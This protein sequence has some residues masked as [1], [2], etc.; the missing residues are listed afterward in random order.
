V[1]L[2]TGSTA[3][4]DRLISLPTIVGPP[5]GGVTADAGGFVEVDEALK[6]CGSQRVWAAG[7]C[8]AAGLEHSALAAQLADAA[9]AAI[10]LAKGVGPTRPSGAPEL[11]GILL[12]GQRDQWLAENPVGTHEPSTRCLWWPPGRAVG[13]IATAAGGNQRASDSPATSGAGAQR[14]WSAS[15]AP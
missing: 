12:S 8:I 14:V 15:A 6:V 3:T 11:T 9:I 2:G 7:G 1:R 5:I 13:R 4:F 10:T